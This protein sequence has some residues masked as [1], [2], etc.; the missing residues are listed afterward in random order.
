M[1]LGC[2]WLRGS[3]ISH[4]WGTNIVTIQGIGTIKTMHVT[5]KLGIQTKILK[6]LVCYNFHFR[7]FDDE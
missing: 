5:M 4:N 3:K 2:S 7:I 1:L 6:V